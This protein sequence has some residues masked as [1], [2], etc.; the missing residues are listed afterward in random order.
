M[1]FHFFNGIIDNIIAK[2]D[3]RDIYAYLD[4]ITVCGKTIKDYGH[5]LKALFIA[6]KSCQKT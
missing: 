2:Y 3:L 5:N 6:A 1:V 4:N